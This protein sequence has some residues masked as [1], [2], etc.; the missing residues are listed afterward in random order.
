LFIQ[1]LELAA[2]VSDADTRAVVSLVVWA[3][4]GL[5]AVGCLGNW[6]FLA[7]GAVLAVSTS[8]KFLVLCALFG[9][10]ALAI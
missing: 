8:Q 3:D 10:A 1:S 5:F 7:I 2:G 6:S 4:D 9:D